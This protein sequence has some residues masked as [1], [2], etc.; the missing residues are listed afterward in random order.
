MEEELRG[1]ENEMRKACAC[2]ET[3]SESEGKM[4]EKTGKEIRWTKS[5]HAGLVF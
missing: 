1:K 3:G 2:E 4:E 5:S